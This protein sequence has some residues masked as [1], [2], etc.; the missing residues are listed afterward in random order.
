[1]MMKYKEYIGKVEYDPEA[2]IFHGEVIG[3]NDV[4]TFQG[5]NPEELEKAFK[6]S[7][8]DYLDWCKELNRS[9]KKI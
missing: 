8:E 1:M 7:I 6:D 9:P 4:I 5:T 3:L 2:K